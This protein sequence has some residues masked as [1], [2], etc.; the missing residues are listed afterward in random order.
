M[1][2]TCVAGLPGSGK[3]HLLTKMSDPYPPLRAWVVDDVSDLG[4]LPSVHHQ[5]TIDHLMISDPHFCITSTRELADCLLSNW[6]LVKPTWI[7]FENDAL[8]CKRNVLVRNDGR[9][10]LG[11]IDSLSG[12]YQIPHDAKHILSVYKP[13]D[14]PEDVC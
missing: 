6:Y 10:V 7:F 1:K 9:K 11:M 5:S 12:I 13:V 8:Q 3:S 4:Q 2:I 14:T